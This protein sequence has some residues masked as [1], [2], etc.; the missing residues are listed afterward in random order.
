MT[1][2]EDWYMSVA[3]GDECSV[4]DCVW[5]SDHVKPRDVQAVLEEAYEAG[6]NACRDKWS[7]MTYQ[8]T[9]EYD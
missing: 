2:F 7:G 8:E 9:R 5:D 1:T 4:H 6:W 3:E